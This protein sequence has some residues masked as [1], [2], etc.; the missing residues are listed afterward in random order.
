MSEVAESIS[1]VVGLFRVSTEAQ[2]KEGYSLA[3]QQAAYQRDC[4]RCGWRSLGTFEG[5]ES[6]SSLQQRHTIHE[7]IAFV[8]DRKP[9]AVWVI[10]QSRLT[11]GD[12]LDVA[13]LI[14]ELRE[15]GTKVVVE[16]GSVIDPQD[17]EGAFMFRLKALFDRR[18]W[19]VIAARNRRGKDEKARRGLLASGRPAYGYR[20]AGEGRDRG[21]RV[22]VPAEA[23]VVRSIFEWIAEG[24][25][26][27]KVIELLRDRGIQAPTES[28]RCSGCRPS[29][30]ANGIQLWSRMTLRRIL[31]NPI[32]VGVAYRNCWVKKGRSFV[33]DRTNP[34]A[35]WVEHAHEPIVTPELWE[36]AQRQMNRRR[37]A[38]HVHLHMLTGLLVCPYCGNSFKSEASC[39][40]GW[41]RQ[42]YVCST[43]V[44][45]RDAV[46]R[47]RRTGN[48]CP[49][50]WLP[51]QQ[52]DQAVWAAFVRL[53]TSPEMIE[54]YLA[55]APATQR[56]AALRAEVDRLQRAAGEIEAKLA[57]ARE[58][59]LSEILT[60]G[61]YLAERER[62]TVEL[63]GLRRH[64]QEKTAA[65]KS[66]SGE[67]TQR[68]IRNL[69][70]LKLGEKKLS[71]DQR[72]K[73]FHALVRRVRFTDQKRQGIEVELYVLPE[74]PET[75]STRA[76]AL[77]P[78]V[79][80]LPVS[81]AVATP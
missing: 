3:A 27:R 77:R 45:V 14:R 51:R 36:A 58:K 56:R 4:R 33:F 2:E 30:Y 76:E 68:V 71:R 46:G 8:R 6:G 18:E 24:H 50:P 81:L 15:T 60:D 55:S 21:Q 79:V 53:V 78:A 38:T 35:I 29:R 34:R 32:Y 43:K 9:D 25:S 66:M 22:P 7:L 39:D 57:R 10:E 20:V 80:A 49:M 74:S 26:I 5:Q 48:A 41:T 17:L 62:L 12:E 42:Y 28:G 16:R 31:L 64:I 73:L 19:E 75:A 65:L 69:A 52:T 63:G 61:E 72:S 67:V 47:R 23:E 70:M 11:R 37:K 54:R 40:E 59:L 44:G 13:I 1:T